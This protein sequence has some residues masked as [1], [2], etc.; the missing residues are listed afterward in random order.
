MVTTRKGF[1]LGGVCALGATR[2]RG[3]KSIPAAGSADV[4]VAGGGPAGLA[5]A[6]TLARAG[7]RVKLFELHGALGGI[8]TSGLLTCLID[9]GR[10][11]LAREI[12]Q[13]LDQFSAR[14]P[15]QMQ[16]LDTNYL[17]EAEYMK[18]VCEE[19]CETSGVD[20]TLHCPVVAAEVEGRRI[21]AVS[22]ESKSGRQRWTA[23]FFVDATGD[24]DLG[25]RAG[26]GFATGGNVP[27][28]PD[29]PASLLALVYLESAP[30]DCVANDPSVF[31]PDGTVPAS[32]KARLRE[33]LRRVGIDPSYGAPTL[34]HLRGNLYALM[35]NHEYAV[36]LDDAKAITRATVRARREL[37]A[38]T[39]ALRTRGGRGWRGVRLLATAE[40]LG[41]R[42]ARRLDGL[43]SLTEHDVASGAK[44]ADAVASCGFLMDVHATTASEN[45]Q[46]LYVAG[47]VDPSQ[48]PSTRFPCVPAGADRDNLYMVGR[49]ISGTF[50]A[51]ASYRVT[52]AAVAMGEGVAHAIVRRILH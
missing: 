49:C 3:G 17:Y 36:P 39:E 12:T 42:A 38:L 40:Q 4:I 20:F 5:C 30:R 15:R 32:P 45:K 24:G 10:S 29:Q 25:A 44:F 18:C 34:F 2:V 31:A 16:M 48:R 28:S 8:W 50:M 37:V 6:I 11:D 46:T 19:M 43:Y 9:F 21:L 52:G 22:T 26:C 13:R 35:A 47:T 41:H 51:Q 27:G 1:I 23:P 33:E 7:V 14:I